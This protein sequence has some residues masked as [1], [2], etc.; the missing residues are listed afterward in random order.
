MYREKGFID[1]QLKPDEARSVGLIVGIGPY[2]VG[3]H[4]PVPRIQ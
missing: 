2:R 4:D 3:V 1:Q